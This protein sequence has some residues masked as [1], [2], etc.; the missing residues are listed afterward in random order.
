MNKW[1]A[2]F[3]FIVAMAISSDCL[4]GMGT[5][6]VTFKYKDNNG[7][8]QPLS[9]AYVYLQDAS[10]NAPM[11]TFFVNAR[12]ILG[13]STLSGVIT[14]SVPEGSYYIRITKRNPQSGNTNKLGPPET[15]DYTWSQTIPIAISANATTNLGTK[16]AGF[17]SSSITITGTI[18]YY[19]NGV[20][21]AGRYVRAQTEPC[22]TDGYNDNVNR[23]GPYKFP[24]QQ[25]TDAN[26]QFTIK[27]RD[28]G[29]Y[30]I[31][32]ST[33]L[34]DVGYEYTGN[35]CMGSYGGTVTV[36]SGE[37]QTLNIVSSLP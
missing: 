23:C 30:Y 26:G 22:Y 2:F 5:L 35:P 25:R 36:N 31:Y 8:E 11:E 6:T 10:R 15:M 9:G 17:F 24:A 27:L 19:I 4:A 21:L 16:Y 20:P 1:I 3:L 12:Y 33:C 29:T 34:S 32:H 28:P 7:I 13:P 14:R 18:T 37:T